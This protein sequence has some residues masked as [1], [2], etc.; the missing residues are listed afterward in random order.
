MRA[1]IYVRDNRT[2]NEEDSLESQLEECLKYATE[3]RL[4]VVEVYK[5]RGAGCIDWGHRD[6]LEA[7]L[8]DAEKKAFD[9]VIVA[10]VACI[11]LCF[12]ELYYCFKKF[13]KNNI[14]V[15]TTRQ[16]VKGLLYPEQECYRDYFNR[17]LPF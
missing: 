4:E 7:L 16:F 10:E 11:S 14:K 5:D 13:W 15:Q 1:V 3:H 2:E 17:E 9:I 6:E 12:F 8:D